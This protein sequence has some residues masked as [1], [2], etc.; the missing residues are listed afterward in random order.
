MGFYRSDGD[1]PKMVYTAH[2]IEACVDMFDT[3][4]G[5]RMRESPWGTAN[6]VYF[7]HNPAN[8]HM[9]L[10]KKNLDLSGGRIRILSNSGKS[11]RGGTEDMVVLDE[12]REF[13]DDSSREKT[14]GPLLNMR[15]SPQLIITSTMG[16]ES[17]GY[18]NRKVSAG[19]KI[20]AAQTDGESPSM[21]LAYFEWGVGDVPPDGYDPADRQL[22]LRAHPMLGY[23]NWT[24]ERMTEKYDIANSEDDIPRF[25]QEYLNQLFAASD[26]PAVPWEILEAVEVPVMRWE[27]LGDDVVLSVFSEPGNYYLSAVAVGNG[28]LKVVR[29]VEE[30]GEV[31]RVRTYAAEEWL[32]GVLDER[33][34]IRRVGYLEGNDL[35]AVLAKFRRK[36]VKM[37]GFRFPDYKEGCR[38]LKKAIIGEQ[39]TIC[40]SGF[41]RIAVAASE[42]VESAD[43]SSW[44]WGRKKVAQ[45]PADELRAAVL[46]WLLYA[47]M[48]DRPKV[49]VVSLRN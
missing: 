42:V 16:V 10:G 32:S 22:W 40:R 15:P 13:G 38:M 23:A 17:S 3:K 11:G 27:D 44:F 36:G 45:A 25:Q 31:R 29:P 14:L 1:D 33:P 5:K 47:R 30:D 37:V 48:I 49:G 19:R 12:A 39:V 41:L 9:R 24:L 35:E 28:K 8:L 34:N 21:R 2:S 43:Q 18:F 46:A 7:N 6:D 4:A 20:A 26:E